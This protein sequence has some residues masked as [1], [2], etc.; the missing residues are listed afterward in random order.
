LALVAFSYGL[1]ELRAFLWR[2]IEC[3]KTYTFLAPAISTVFDT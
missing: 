2:S 1:F 3:A